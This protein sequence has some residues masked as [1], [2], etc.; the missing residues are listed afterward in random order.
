MS[1][2]AVKVIPVAT[3]TVTCRTLSIPNESVAFK[4][5][6]YVPTETEFAIMSAPPTRV[7]PL[8]GGLVASTRVIEPVPPDVV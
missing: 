1:S 4:V 7:I 6:S 8:Y 3:F 5:I 2:G